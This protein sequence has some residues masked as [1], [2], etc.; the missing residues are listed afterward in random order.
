MEGTIVMSH[1]EL[2][3]ARVLEQVLHEKLGLNEAG[4]LLQISYRQIRRVMKRYREQGAAGLVHGNRGRPSDRAVTAAGAARILALHDTTY[5]DFNDSHFTEKLAEREGIT[6]NRETIRRILRRAGKPP[7]R[8]RRPRRHRSRRP[9][10]VAPGTMIQ[11]D[12]SPHHWFG[13]D[14]PP[15]CLMAAIDDA[16]SKLLAALFV[17]AESALAYL[18]LLDKVLQHHGVPLS[19]YHDRHSALQRTDTFWSLEEQLAG[20]RFP[21]HVGRVLDEFAIQSIPAFS[22]QAKGRI[23]RGFGVCQDR[24]VAELRLEGITDPATANPWLETS[25][26][27]RHNQRFAIK[28]QESPA[29]FRKTSA[30]ERYHKIAFAYEATV[31]NDNAVRLGGLTID[32]PPGAHRRSYAHATVLVKQHLDGAWTVWYQEQRIATHQ[33]T[34]LTEPVRAWKRRTAPDPTAARSMIQVYINS[35]PAPPPKRTFSRCS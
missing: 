6:F 29:V 2:H 3:R 31:A 27:P 7:K 1:K 10:K 20:V 35:K 32:I 5:T 11:W 13:P 28:V 34:P 19:I 26:I 12:G 33:S 24:L 9:R 25:F 21:T 16:N 15:C 17:P 14:Q 22:P 18:Q 8:P 4:K 30:R 23:E